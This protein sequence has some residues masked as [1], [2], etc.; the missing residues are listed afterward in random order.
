[1][2]GGGNPSDRTPLPFA[3]GPWRRAPFPCLPALAEVLFLLLVISFSSRE[4]EGSPAGWTPPGRRLSRTIQLG[5]RPR[6]FS[7][8]RC[9]GAEAGSQG[10]PLPAGGWF[11]GAR[12]PLPGAPLRYGGRTGPLP[13]PFLQRRPLAVPGGQPPPDRRQ[14][15][16]GDQPPA[17]DDGTA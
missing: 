10:R 15:V 16:H 11:G 5:I 13:G 9:H 8:R 2:S 1:A 7:P 17:G 6:G 3:S 12:A 14:V 4:V